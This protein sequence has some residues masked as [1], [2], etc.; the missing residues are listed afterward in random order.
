MAIYITL[1]IAYFIACGVVLSRFLG[2]K[3]SLSPLQVYTAY[4]FKLLLSALYGYLFLR[5]YNGDDTWELHRETLEA[6]NTLFGSPSAFFQNFL[7]ATSSTGNSFLESLQIYFYNLEQHLIAG[8]LAVTVPITGGDYYL[9]AIFT[10]SILFIGQCWLYRTLAGIFLQ[11]TRVLYLLIFWFAPAVFWLS[12]LRADGF[13]FLAF[14]GVLLFFQKWLISKK[15]PGLIKIIACLFLMLV[16]RA[17]WVFITVPGLVAWYI[18]EKW[19]KPPLKIFLYS[20]GTCLLL[21]ILSAFLPGSFNLPSIIQ[22]KQAAFI[23]L[24]GT[25]YN[26]PAI[27]NSMLSWLKILPAAIQN[28]FLRPYLWEAEGPLQMMAAFETTLLILLFLATVL[29]YQKIKQVLKHPVICLMLFFS[30]L[31]YLSVGITVPFPGAIVRYR[32]TGELFLLIILLMSLLQKK[33]I[34]INNI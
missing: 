9:M 31:L 16:F 3:A 32:I 11:Q 27:D 22:H 24:T 23:G 25:R 33:H 21:F 15:P 13:L 10:S 29:Q 7:P 20:Y 12:G 28:S 1:F 8:L 14:S 18:S 26:L 2:K 6:W 19:K 4:G 17:Q 30:I 34:K 5:F